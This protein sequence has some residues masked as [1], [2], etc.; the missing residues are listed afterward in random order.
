[1]TWLTYPFASRMTIDRI[2]EEVRS[3]APSEGADGFG[4][5]PFG[6]VSIDTDTAYQQS[7]CGELSQRPAPETAT[8]KKFLD[9][10]QDLGGVQPPIGQYVTLA[11]NG[12]AQVPQIEPPSL[13][14]G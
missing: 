6:C 8:A 5:V 14:R 12:R 4:D 9:V 7:S 10:Q 1:M 2:A 3:A 11:Q 13:G